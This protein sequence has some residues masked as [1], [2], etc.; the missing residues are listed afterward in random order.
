[1]CGE[2]S[3]RCLHFSKLVRPK[4]SQTIPLPQMSATPKLSKEVLEKALIANGVTPAATIPEMTAQL[5]A[6][7]AAG[8]QRPRL[9]RELRAGSA[10]AGHGQVPARLLPRGGDQAR[11]PRHDGR[12]RLARRGA[13]GLQDCGFLWAAQRARRQ[14]R[15][16]PG[17]PQRRTLRGAFVA[18]LLLVPAEVQHGK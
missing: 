16:Q 14:R 3:S 12:R 9:R 1:M 13:L 7:A 4:N 11:A 10:A 5:H 15:S 2:A 6:A 18:S 17:P 8:R